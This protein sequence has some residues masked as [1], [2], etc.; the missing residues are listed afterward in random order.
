MSLL[1]PPSTLTLS[2]RPSPPLIAKFPIRVFV[3]SKLPT[4][5]ASGITIAS[6]A[7]VRLR[8]GRFWISTGVT[9][10]L[11]SD[12]VVSTIGVLAATVTVS[13][14]SPTSSVTGTVSRLPTLTSRAG[15]LT[16]L[17]PVS[18]AVT[19][20]LPGGSCVRRYSPEV[21][22][23]VARVN[24]VPS[25]RAVTVVPAM[26]APVASTTLPVISPVVACAHTV[27]DS[28]PMTPTTASD[29]NSAMEHRVV[30]MLT[31][32]AG[33]DFE[34]NTGVKAQSAKD[35]C[36][37]RGISSHRP[38]VGRLGP[39]PA[40]FRLKSAQLSLST[41]MGSMDAARRAGR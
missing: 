27:V 20:Y 21:L 7:N 35:L 18:S 16:V 5:R 4:G 8:T 6:D 36:H 28:G 26:T 24:P 11:M 32:V 29:T 23:L 19:V 2:C 13:V 14:R 17:N 3:G 22:V 10:P 34:R 31:S 37:C 25:C 30:L 15:R 33:S 41:A 9:T 1:S 38:E 39:D 12:R 40:R